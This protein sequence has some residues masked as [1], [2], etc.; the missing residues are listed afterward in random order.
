[1]AVVDRLLEEVGIDQSTAAESRPHQFSGGQCQ[2]VAIARALVLDPCLVICDQPVSA[3]DV[4][5]QARVLNL[6]EDL[7]SRHGLSLLFIAHDLA[8]VNAASD[9]VAGDVPR[10]ALRGG[11][12]RA[13]L[14]R[15]GAPLH[16][17]VYYLIP[18]PDPAVPP[19]P[20]AVGEPLLLVFTRGAQPSG[21]RFA[22]RCPW[23]TSICAD[24]EPTLA[25]V[26]AEGDHFV[27]CHHPLTVTGC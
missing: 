22:P 23:A 11:G 6:L 18:V 4:S 3:V 21:C 15:P 26:G 10:Q 25:S 17:A 1:M 7:K 27:A 5:V 9:R 16:A 20:P 12:Q 2:R 8:V 13:A 19:T 14:R 24:V